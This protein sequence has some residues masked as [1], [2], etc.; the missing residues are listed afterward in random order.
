MLS[1]SVQ[2]FHF[3]TMSIEYTQC[4]KNVLL[5]HFNSLVAKDACVKQTSDYRI[6]FRWTKF[7]NDTFVLVLLQVSRQDWSSG[8]SAGRIS[9]IDSFDMKLFSM[10]AKP[11]CSS[12]ARRKVNNMRHHMNNVGWSYRW[13]PGKWLAQFLSGCLS[14]ELHSTNTSPVSG[15]FRL[16]FLF[17]I[18]HL[19]NYCLG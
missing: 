4:L 5:H 9:Y 1:Y 2:D 17:R 14:V 18:D 10:W 16:H 13:P 12:T 19:H 7:K 15:K 3:V 11:T 8:T 6:T